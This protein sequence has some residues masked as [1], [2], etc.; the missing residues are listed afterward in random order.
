MQSSMCSTGKKKEWND[1]YLLTPLVDSLGV[2]FCLTYTQIHS[3]IKLYSLD[4][5]SAHV[6]VELTE[7]ASLSQR[8]KVSNLNLTLNL[9]QIIICQTI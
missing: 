7:P 4:N 9:T 2:I 6:P 1:N 3:N 8:K 5:R